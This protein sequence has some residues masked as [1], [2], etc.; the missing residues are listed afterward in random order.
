MLSR[1]ANSI[2]WMS[3]YLERADNVARFIDVN[4]HLMLDMGLEG[5]ST[6]WLPLVNASGDESNFQ[7]RY[8]KADE[9]SVVRF[10]TFDKENPNSIINCIQ[11]AREN[12]R[13]VREVIP[14]D[15]WEAINLL[16]HTVEKHSRKRRIDNLQEFLD[17]IRRSSHMVAGLIH[18]N[19]SHGE[20]WHFARMG[21]MLERADKT[22]RMLD[23]KY[24][25]LLPQ[26]ETVDSPHDAVEWG[27]VLKSANAFE[28]YRKQFHR[29]NYRNVVQFL[30]LDAHFPRSMAFCV[31][32]A[33]ASLDK[34]TEM[35]G[36]A[37]RAQ[38]EMAI[39]HNSLSHTDTD[40]VLV[41]GLHDFIDIF[42]FNLNVVDQS[43][44]DSFFSMK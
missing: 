26:N 43:I 27:A 12:A 28:M 35:T 34:I 37:M 14:S 20:G 44:Y 40:A 16:Y 5:A 2:Y 1:V 38:K 18:N 41:S 24:F 21:K 36:V 22:A 8:N 25:L 4:V 42:Q 3:R 30:M 23:V 31:A 29:V 6:Q 19:M 10:L 15:L 17:D 9:K 11:N 32:T 7:K 33:S 39:L 13:T